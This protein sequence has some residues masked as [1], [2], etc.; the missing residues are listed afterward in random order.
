MEQLMTQSLR[1]FAAV[2][3][4][5]LSL[6]AGIARADTIDTVKVQP[7]GQSDAVRGATLKPVQ[8]GALKIPTITWGGDV[9]TVLAQDEGLFKA[10]GL[11]TTLFHEDDFAKQVRGVLDGNTPFLRGTFGMI[12]SAAETFH[13]AGTDLVVL[14]QMTWS[15]GGDVLVVR[16]GKDGKEIKTLADLKGKTIALQLYGP[17]MDLLTTVLNRA[18]LQISDVKIVWFKEL[19]T[20]SYDT[21]GHIVDTRSAFAADPSIDAAFVISPDAAALTSNSA[22]GGGNGSDGSV[23]GAKVL[24]S[25]KSA[26]HVIADVYAVRKDWYDAHKDQAQEFVH[27]MM[28]GQEHFDALVANKATDKQHYNKMME[29]AATLLVGSAQGAGDVEGMLGDA[30]FVGFGGNVAFFTAQG[31]TRNFNVLKDEIQQSFITLKLLS[32]TAPVAKAD[33]DY[34]KLATG[35]AHADLT[36]VP[37]TTFDTTKAQASIEHQ[38]ASEPT[39]WDEDGTLYIFEIYFKPNQ[40]DFTAAQY[41]DAFNKVLELS[42]TFGGAIVTVEG[43]NAPDLL[44]KARASGNTAQ[45]QAIEQA[46]KNLSKLRAEKVR[47]AYLDFIQG[48]GIQADPS[49]FIAVGMG[50]THPKF[51]VPA[52]KEE[53]SQNMRVVFRIKSV[54][55][56]M[57]SFQAPSK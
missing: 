53:W 10:E 15:R 50:A 6:S 11:S 19:T 4:I 52:T 51:A 54:E 56:E 31:T 57:D 32:G 49:Q 12:N 39:A 46:A 35:L 5:A 14:N 17:H 26:D 23:K 55:T 3:A 42:Q 44:N 13:Q 9:P 38:I 29:S 8:G 20:P 24:F 48:K 40:A 45:A 25:T 47:A 27:A 7:I 1:N 33:W 34:A 41:A 28:V 36:V 16:P 18:G 22:A 2:A 21:K 30:E 37:R 43:H